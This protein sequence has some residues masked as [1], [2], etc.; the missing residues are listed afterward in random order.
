M[1]ILDN[2]TT[3][4]ETLSEGSEYGDGI[5][6]A[7]ALPIDSCDAFRGTDAG[8]SGRKGSAAAV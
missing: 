4:F 1:E 5:I 7:D 2:I 8:I 6:E 3:Y